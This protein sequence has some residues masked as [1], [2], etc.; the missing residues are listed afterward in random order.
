MCEVRHS[1]MAAAGY[2]EPMMKRVMV[3]YKVEQGRAAENEA[4]IR[5]VFAE[6]AEKAPAGLRYVSFKLEDG[7][8]FVH[9]ASIETD[10][11]RNPLAE[12]DAF[13]AFVADIGG[14]CDEPP[15]AA[16]A[17]VIGGY[18]VFDE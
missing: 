1:Y 3:R 11:G 4:L 2:G 5:N 10:D 15:V 6:L 18:R 9:V 14:R 12:L 16:A 17:E 7:V 13:K 8:S